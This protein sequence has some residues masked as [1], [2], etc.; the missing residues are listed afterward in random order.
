MKA[1][2]QEE[3]FLIEASSDITKSNFKEKIL[4][5]I[6]TWKINNNNNYDYLIM[7]EAFNWKRLAIRIVVYLKLEKNLQN[8]IIEW[9]MTP[10][11]YATFSEEKFKNLIG[12]EKYN[13][14]LSYFYGITIERCLISYVEQELLKKQP[15]DTTELISQNIRLLPK[16]ITKIVEALNLRL[17]G[18]SEMDN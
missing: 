10:H 4:Y 7:K 14:N 18:L 12:F 15:N 17:E 9:L 8:L 13:A 16:I 2:N 3:K 5:I 11:L 1:F 6:G